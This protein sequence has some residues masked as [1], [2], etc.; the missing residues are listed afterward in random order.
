MNA[1]LQNVTEHPTRQMKPVVRWVLKEL[2]VDRNDLAVH[3]ERTPYLQHSGK[4]YPHCK[5]NTP[6]VWELLGASLPTATKHVIFTRIPNTPFGR[7]ERGLR[8]GPPPIVPRDWK[9]SLVCIVA[10]EGWHMWEFLHP[11]RGKE[12]VRRTK[13]GLVV[14]RPKLHSEVDAEWAEYRLLKRW[15]ER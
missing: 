14:V 6:K 13:R 4:L 3:V 2:G 9:E 5:K 10:H 1:H 12:H 7:H 8:G 11:R 15:R